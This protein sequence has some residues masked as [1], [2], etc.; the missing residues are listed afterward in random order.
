VTESAN[1]GEYNVLASG[2]PSGIRI[3]DDEHTKR[4]AEPT[5][6]EST[7]EKHDKSKWAAAGLGAAGVGAGAAALSS[8]DPEDDKKETDKLEP[9]EQEQIKQ[10]EIEEA[11]PN[12]APVVGATASRPDKVIHKCNKCG[13]ENDISN[14]FASDGSRKI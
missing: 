11:K 9:I 5:I 2:T 13:E 8:R 3:E 7:E 10:Y 14:Y 1:H 4:S 6:P 12:S